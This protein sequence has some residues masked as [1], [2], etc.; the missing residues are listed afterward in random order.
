M[1][2]WFASCGVCVVQCLRE[3]LAIKSCYIRVF[4]SMNKVGSKTV[5]FTANIIKVYLSVS[6]HIKDSLRK[7]V[8]CFITLQGKP[9]VYVFIYVYVSM[10]ACVCMYVLVHKPPSFEC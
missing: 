3:Y 9:Y 4:S 10:H 7:V 8:W 2:K 5:I 1:L 6:N